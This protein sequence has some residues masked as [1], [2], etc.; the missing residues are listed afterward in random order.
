MGRHKQLTLPWTVALNFGIGVQ[1]PL[2]SRRTEKRVLRYMFLQAL[3]EFHWIPCG[4][5]RKK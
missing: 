2:K 1:R 5:A 3:Q 4:S